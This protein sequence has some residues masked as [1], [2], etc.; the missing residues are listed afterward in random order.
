VKVNEKQTNE[1]MEKSAVVQCID[2]ICGAR[3]FGG[4]CSTFDIPEPRKH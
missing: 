1:Y 3:G 2:V 4:T